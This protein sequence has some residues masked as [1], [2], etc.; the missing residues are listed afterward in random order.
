MF[1]RWLAGR[2]RLWRLALTTL[3][4]A[5]SSLL[6]KCSQRGSVPTSARTRHVTQPS[7]TRPWYMM[8]GC[9]CA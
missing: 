6:A 2:L 7:S 5:H 3:W 9:C 8:I 4:S 1:V